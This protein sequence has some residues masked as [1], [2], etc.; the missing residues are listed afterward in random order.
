M[1]RRPTI[2]KGRWTADEHERF[3][4]SLRIYG[5]DW[6]MIQWKV[7]TRDRKNIMAHAQKFKLKME[8]IVSKSKSIEEIEDAKR[9]IIILESKQH[10][11]FSNQ[12]KLFQGAAEIDDTPEKPG[13]FLVSD[14]ESVLPDDA[15]ICVQPA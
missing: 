9:Y 7:G 3:Q 5:K 4:Y 1:Y 13:I 8:K 15:P 14:K 12:L 11:T 2:R 6:R 10:K